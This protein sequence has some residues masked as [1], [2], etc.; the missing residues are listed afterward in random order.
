MLA[1]I[2]ITNHQPLLDLEWR[3]QQELGLSVDQQSQQNQDLAHL[4]LPDPMEDR[5][6]TLKG[7]PDK[8][9]RDAG[10]EWYLHEEYIVPEAVRVTG[11]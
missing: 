7:T 3:V 2:L 1:I 10:Y 5:I 8:Q 6:Y 9:I 11:Q 4:D